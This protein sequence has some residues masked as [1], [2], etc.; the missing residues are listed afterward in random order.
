[1]VYRIREDQ[2][3][4][5]R[6]SAL[7]DFEEEMILHS[8][9][10]SPKLCEVLGDDQIR[11]SVQQA[12]AKAQTYGFSNRGPIRLCIELM[13]LC[14]SHFDTD[15]QYP[16][17]GKVLNSKDEQMDRA[18]QICQGVDD[19]VDKVAGEK[20]IHVRK[21][22]E[23]L[24]DFASSPINVS[25]NELAE[26]LVREMTN[27][28]PQKVAYMGNDSLLKLIEEGRNEARKHE[29]TSV[30]AQT[31]I[32]VLMFAFGHGCTH[33]P[34]YPWIKRTLRDEQIVDSEARARR[35]EK[36]AV[37]WLTHVLARY[38]TGAPA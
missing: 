35:L 34:L 12:I 1:M 17:I 2:I 15:P 20:N 13:F 31:L 8:K 32:V 18:G 24:A 27:A 5:F 37:T 25:E 7:A 26:T 4:E 22:E 28:Y 10:F 11:V 19:Y 16:A 36:K 6:R 33:D 3:A 38:Q 23:F 21:A 9:N 14:G 29:L 30:R